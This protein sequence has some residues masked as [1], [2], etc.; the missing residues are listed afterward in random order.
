MLLESYAFDVKVHLG[1][2]FSFPHLIIFNFFKCSLN[3]VLHGT[4][5]I[6]FFPRFIITFLN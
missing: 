6:G 5:L 2:K 4:L 1:A 3:N